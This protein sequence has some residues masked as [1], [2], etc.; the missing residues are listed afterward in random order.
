MLFFFIKMKQK[1]CQQIH[2]VQI[3]KLEQ[4]IKTIFFNKIIFLHASPKYSLIS[5]L[6]V[7]FLTN[8]LLV[9]LNGWTGGNQ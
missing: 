2:D 8:Y 6:N 4:K 7:N 1:K 9:S 5:N 3:K